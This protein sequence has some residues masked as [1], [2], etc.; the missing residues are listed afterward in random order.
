MIIKED[1]LDDLLNSTFSQ[2]VNCGDEVESS[3][4]G[5]NEIRN[6]QLILTNPRARLSISESRSKLISCIGEFFWYVNGSDSIE[7][8]EYYISNYRDFID[9]KQ[10]ENAPV[11]GAYGSRMFGIKNQFKAIKDLLKRKP[12]TRRAVISIYDKEDLFRDDSRDIPCTCS[13]Q[14]FVRDNALHL[15]TIMRSNDATKGLI[16]DLFSF[17]LIQELMWAELAK[18]NEALELGIYTHFAGS[19]HI[20][21]E[22]KTTV[23]NFLH[24]EGWQ[25]KATMEPINPSYLENDFNTIKELEE[26]LRTKSL[27]DDFDIHSIKDIFWQEIA[28]ILLSYSYA[29]QGRQSE[30]KE[31]R[32]LCR[33]DPILYFLDKK[34]NE[35]NRKNF[36]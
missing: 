19:L 10:G 5:N 27:Q 29:K 2:I 4:G 1:S 13:L 15:T 20:Y 6:V 30:L 25:N 35:I 36:K 3:K 18:D 14:F 26:K 32:D 33:S 17:T 31:L 8:I 9:Y 28:I 21:H 34:I 11:L 16:H 23:D 12:E 22:D 7:F 24:I